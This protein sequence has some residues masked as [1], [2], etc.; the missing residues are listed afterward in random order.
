M[1]SLLLAAAM[2]LFAFTSK[3]FANDVRVTPSTLLTVNT[4]FTNASDVKWA[5]NGRMYRADFMIEGEKTVAFFDSKDGSLVVTCHYISISQLPQNLQ[6]SL[7]AYTVA[8]TIKEVF[9]V[10]E[11]NAR[12][13]YVTITKDD[14]T[15]VLRSG[16]KKWYVFKKK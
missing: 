2:M 3:I 16:T 6:H 12:D 15:T 14:E 10:Q 7:K 8:A 11:D 1:K 9:V 13:Y 4:T 5:V